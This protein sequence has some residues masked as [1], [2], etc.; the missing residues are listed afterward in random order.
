MT[1]TTQTNE[2]TEGQSQLT[3]VLGA[4]WVSVTDAHAPLYEDVLVIDRH[5]HQSVGRYMAHGTYTHDRYPV[6]GQ[7][8][9]THW[10][11]LPEA[12]NGKAQP[13]RTG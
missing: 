5:N 1:E 11:L 7:A 8:Q 4:G 3:E 2:A 12:P 6:L 10:R 9:V 13:G